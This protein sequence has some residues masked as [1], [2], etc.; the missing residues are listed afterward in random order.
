MLLMEGDA[1]ESVIDQIIVGHRTLVGATGLADAALVVDQ[2]GNP[3]PRGTFT[4]LTLRLPGLR[5]SAMDKDH[6]RNRSCAFWQKQTSGKLQVLVVKLDPVLLKPGCHP[7]LNSTGRWPAHA[8]Q[9]RDDKERGRQQLF[10]MDERHAEKHA[11]AAGLGSGDGG[12]EASMTRQ[13][14]YGP[15]P[16]S[17]SFALVWPGVC[18]T[19]HFE[20]SLR[21]GLPP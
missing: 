17:V 8:H 12:R 5:S 2:F 10:V 11:G 15:L 21:V 19:D 3:L 1:G 13:R 16:A 9:N 18:C 4:R 20:V 6:G 7:G 14:P